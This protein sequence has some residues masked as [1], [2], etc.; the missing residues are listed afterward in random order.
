MKASKDSLASDTNSRETQ[1]YHKVE[2]H[3]IGQCWTHN[4]DGKSS[5]ISAHS[6]INFLKAH[7]GTLNGGVLNKYLLEK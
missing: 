5:D 6:N 3:W 1:R 4:N 7:D 2:D